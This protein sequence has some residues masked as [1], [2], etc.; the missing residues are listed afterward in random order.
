LL[1]R[2]VDSA[3]EVLGDEKRIAGLLLD[4]ENASARRP[5]NNPQS[6]RI[7]FPPAV[8][9]CIEPVTVRVAPQN[10]TLGG[11]GDLA[12]RCTG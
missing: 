3:P 6:S 8:N 10:V 4:G 7:V 12:I 5:W 9:W 1:A 2:L 11:C